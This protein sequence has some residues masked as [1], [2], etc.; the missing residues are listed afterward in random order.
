MRVTATKHKPVVADFREQFLKDRQLP[1]P[2]ALS[3]D[4]LRIMLTTSCTSSSLTAVG[5]CQLINVSAC[6]TM[7]A[8]ASYIHLHKYNR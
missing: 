3:E 4:R 1:H 2:D 6:M 8:A 5:Q 7:F